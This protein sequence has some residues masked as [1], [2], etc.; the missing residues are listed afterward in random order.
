MWLK[1]DT[2]P[3][4]EALDHYASLAIKGKRGLVIGSESPWLEAMLLEYGATSVTTI[5]WSIQ[6][7]KH[8]TLRVGNSLS[9]ANPGVTIPHLE[10]Y[11]PEDFTLDFLEGRIEPFDFAF[12]HSQL[13]HD[14]LGRYGDPI[15]PFGDL[16]TMARLLTIVKPG[17]FMFLG[18]PC[19]VDSVY[20]NAHR[21][22]GRVRFEEMFAGWKVLSSFPAD[23]LRSGRGKHGDWLFQPVWALQ[24]PTGCI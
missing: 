22:Y 10:V 6:S 3:V 9:L 15:N 5:D 19:C 17:G 12:S 13:E 24:N 4:Y 11:A 23:A 14:G 1:Y 18:V 21:V 2:S 16:H 20:W 8:S 7:V